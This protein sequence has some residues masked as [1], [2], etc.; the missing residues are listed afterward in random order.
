MPELKDRLPPSALLKGLAAAANVPGARLL[1]EPTFLAERGI[2]YAEFEVTVEPINDL[3]SVQFPQITRWYLVASPDYPHG[4][5]SVRPAKEGG[6][7]DTYPHQAH[8]SYGSSA[9]PWRDG[10]LCLDHPHRHLGSLVVTRDEPFEVEERFKWVVERAVAW[11]LAASQG[12]L[13]K[14]GDPFELPPPPTLTGPL[15]VHDESKECFGSWSRVPCGEW[16]IVELGSFEGHPNAIVADTF[17]TRYRTPL[18]RRLGCRTHLV[19]S[20]RLKKDFALWWLWKDAVVIDKW[21][22][23]RNWRE[24]REAGRQQGIPVNKHLREMSRLARGRGPRFLFIGYPI[25]SKVGQEPTEVHWQAIEFPKLTRGRV[26]RGFRENE[27]G[28]WYRDSL[29]DF[30]G[31]NELRYIL[32]SNWHPDR[33]QARGRLASDLRSQKCA[34]IGCGALGSAIADLLVRGGVSRLVLIDPDRLGLENLVRHRLYGDDVG[35]LKA[36][37]LREKLITAAPFCEI[38]VAPEALPSESAKFFSML[39]TVDVVIDCTGAEDVLRTLARMQ[40]SLRKLFVSMSFGYEARRL[41]IYAERGEKISLP[42]FRKYIDPLLREDDRAWRNAGEIFEGP[43]CWSPIFPAR[44]D[45]ILL[46]AAASIRVLEELVITKSAGPSLDLLEREGGET[47]SQLIRKTYS[48]PVEFGEIDDVPGLGDFGQGLPV[49]DQGLSPE[50]DK[51]VSR[52]LTTDRD[53]GIVAGQVP[54]RRRNRLRDRGD[55]AAG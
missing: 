55:R 40:F 23:P 29:R 33:M 36:P 45:D 35:R 54:R 10:T 44:L 42:T 6:I 1:G 26:L 22:V 2:W 12:G 3:G 31:A 43:G 14:V 47:F 37:A 32:T 30:R 8:N 52:E 46:G 53:R 20:R 9:N 21:Q 4:N 16:G 39:D 49:E 27:M 34:I 28:W 48:S 51:G 38:E 24:L 11:C 7:S 17:L 50:A 19:N 15:L 13:R 18:R 25:P 41:F 5:V